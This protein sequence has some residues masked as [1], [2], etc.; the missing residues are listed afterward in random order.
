[1]NVI[2]IIP[3]RMAATR[4]PNKPLAKIAGIPMVGHVYYR[5]LLARS[6]SS[7]YVAT[8]DEAIRGYCVSIGA[9]CVMTSNAHQRASERAAE[10]AETIERG[11][12]KTSD[13]VMLIQGDEPLLDPELIDLCVTTM[14]RRSNAVVVN[15]LEEIDN[16]NDFESVNTVKVVLRGDD[17]L[18]YLSREPIPSRRKWPGEMRRIKQLGLIAFRRDF[19][20]TY[21][22]LRPTP[23]EQIESVDMLR[24]L[25]HGYEIQGLVVSGRSIG[26]DTPDDLRRA[27]ELMATDLLLPSYKR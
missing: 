9:P 19:L 26:V 13:A 24:V 18:L 16:D 11:N 8:C 5:S 25:E 23:L 15:L 14:S 21:S 27:E 20:R 3:A 1:M 22:S 4:F 2:G 6:L 7:V 10:A 12:G 17:T